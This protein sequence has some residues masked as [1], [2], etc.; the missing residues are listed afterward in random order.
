[1]APKPVAMIILSDL[2]RKLICLIASE[3]SNLF[4]KVCVAAS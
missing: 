1:M 3:S 4:I 2:L